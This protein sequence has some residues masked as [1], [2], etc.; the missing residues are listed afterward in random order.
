MERLGRLYV[1]FYDL[2]NKL[3]GIRVIDNNF[4]NF[5]FR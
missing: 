5:K 1:D 2:G 3:K 4:R